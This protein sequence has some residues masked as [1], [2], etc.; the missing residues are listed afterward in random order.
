MFSSAPQDFPL[1]S[2]L[3]GITLGSL[4]LVTAVA[5]VVSAKTIQALFPT[6]FI[7]ALA[8]AAARQRL[9][10]ARFHLDGVTLSLLAFVFYAGLSALWASKPEASALAAVMAALIA[11]ASLALFQ[12]MHSE[13]HENA[14][15]MGEG[16]WIGLAIGLL[17]VL[18]EI[19]SDQAIKIGIYNALRLPPDAL[20]P[21]RYFTWESNRIVAIHSDD[22]TRNAAPIPLLIWPALMA[23]GALPRP[24]WRPLVS[25][26]LFVLAAAAVV[27]GPNETAKLALLASLAVY[28]LARHSP[29]VIRYSLAGAWIVACLGVA[30][31]AL[32]A[33]HLQL[34]NAGWLQLSAQQRV[35]I[36]NEVATLIPN[37]PIFGVGAD[38]TYVIRPAMHESPPAL[39]G[40]AG[41][42]IVHPHNLYLQTWYELGAVGA[43]L[44]TLFGLALVRN[45]AGLSPILQPFAL[46]MFTSAAVLVGFSYGM[47]QIWFICLFGFAAAM[48]GLGQRVLQKQIAASRYP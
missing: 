37:A 5:V 7:V 35:I 11:L 43:V 36:F 24:V 21:A 19:A 15:H 12:L 31:L 6:L 17:Y 22:L 48:Y 10:C 27:L 9:M 46:A 3:W 14:L 18:V 20:A 23:A 2:R 47:W 39:P 38:M 41:F 34:Q 26:C 33:H 4:I 32:L 1:R 29:R 40:M 8:A 44:L 30:P 28:V 45:I 16:L 42:P 13:R 25:G